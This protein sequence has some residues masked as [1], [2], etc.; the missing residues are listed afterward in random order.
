ML[1]NNEGQKHNCTKCKKVKGLDE[2]YSK[3]KRMD[4]WCKECRK[5]NRMSRYH[6]EKEKFKRFKNNRIT[7]VVMTRVVMTRVTKV[8]KDKI[9]I[10]E[11]MLEKMIVKALT[12]KRDGSTT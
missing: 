12:E 11:S 8:N 1:I 3:G 10:I 4:S 9:A 6:K 5:A 7:R 2:F